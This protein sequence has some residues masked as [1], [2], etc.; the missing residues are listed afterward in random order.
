MN[1]NT[2]ST[3]TYQDYLCL[4]HFNYKIS[5]PSI[6]L[7]V[8]FSVF[9]LLYISFAL[10]FI[11]FFSVHPSFIYTPEIMIIIFRKSST[12]GFFLACADKLFICFFFLSCN[13]NSFALF[14][15]W[16]RNQP[17]NV[18]LYVLRNMCLNNKHTAFDFTFRIWFHSSNFQLII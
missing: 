1:I 17:Q 4:L 18:F 2:A 6:W 3:S 12:K 16:E 14:S 8:G 7:D 13:Q 9:P 5:L 15:K 10:F 11:F